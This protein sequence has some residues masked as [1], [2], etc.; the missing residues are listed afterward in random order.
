MNKYFY[1][2]LFFLSCNYYLNAQTL[3]GKTVNQQ[4]ESI[5]GVTV[6]MQ[7]QDSVFVSLAYS[8]SSGGFSFTQRPEGEVRL[9]F[10]HLGCE[11]LLM[12]VQ[13]DITDVGNVTLEEKML[14]LEDVVVKARRPIVK[15]EG[16]ALSFDVKPIVQNNAVSTAF[17]VI[18]E[19]P[20][21]MGSD[22]QISLMGAN[23]LS[24]IVDGKSNN[25]STEQIYSYL[26]TI[27]A[28]RV[29]KV[30]VMYN[31]PA[32]YGIRG[33]L[34]NV[35][36]DKKNNKTLVGELNLMAAQSHYTSGKL[37]GNMFYSSGKNFNL[38]ASLELS[39]GKDWTNTTTLS[40]QQMDSMQYTVNQNSINSTG[41]DKLDFR[42]GGDYTFQNESQLSVIYFTNL[43]KSKSIVSSNDQYKYMSDFDVNSLNR[44]TGSRQL[45]NVHIEY[46]NKQDLTLSVDFTKY[47]APEDDY[48]TTVQNNTLTN[49]F[50]NRSSQNISQ[51][52]ISVSK[53]DSIFHKCTFNYGINSGYN[54]S[55]TNVNYLYP[56]EGV[57]IGDVNQHVST[58]QK[59]YT[60][61]PFVEFSHSLFKKVS[62]VYGLE[63]E[64]F[65][66]DYTQGNT[67]ETLW[68]MISLFPK[69]TISYPLSVNHNFQLNLFYNRNYP[70]YWSV[71]PQV[72]YTSSYTKIVGNP[73]LIPDK[74]YNGQFLYIFKQR[75]M[76]M[77][78]IM[79]MP[80]YFAL[81]P[82]QD[83]NEMKTVYQYVNYDFSLF[84]ALSV[85]F[86]ITVNKYW[87]FRFSLHGLRMEDKLN[88][89]HG[90]AFDNNK[91]VGAIAMNHT[92]F[93]SKSNPNLSFQLNG[94]YQSPSIQ[95]IYKLGATTNLSSALKWTLKDGSYFILQYNNMLLRQIPNPMI[96]DFAN[97][98]SHRNSREMS[99][100]S[101]QFIYKIGDFKKKEY[102][103][104]DDSRFL[105]N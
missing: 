37:G 24:I 74:E 73:K 15:M 25:L 33:A 23:N 16:N 91:Y 9:L 1:S 65:R 43:S 86:P 103:K 100:V 39:E 12:T 52:K 20:C 34:I 96:V 75:Y 54:V 85:I 71:S 13:P 102:K 48:F 3:S 68:N 10:Q 98:Y 59:E 69:L 95:G 83:S 27:P 49:D 66:S 46:D 67:T 31:A 19:L 84:S 28:S 88:D 94:R 80:N 36:C 72:S 21:I 29:Q 97:Q 79:Y 89:F 14:A 81:L 105:R 64:Y 30:E 70:S 35:I 55:N 78:S 63:G 5:E 2:I 7:T 11:P 26:K 32:K 42:L 17:D 56:Q 57:Y 93:I 44:G 53:S 18:K 82:Y 8:D 77:A 45:H 87:N 101:V 38:D 61:Q 60:M 90:L 51:S 40:N 62:L 99:T 4:G 104:P 6:I 41:Y 76:L 92:V 58:Q 50:L 22:E 47:Y